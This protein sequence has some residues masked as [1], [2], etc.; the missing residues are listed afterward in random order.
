MARVLL[1]FAHPALEGSRV[2]RRLLRAVPDGVTVHDLYD[3]Y[4]DFGSTVGRLLS[5]NGVAPVVLD[6]DAD[7]VDFLRRIGL[8]VYYGDA[9][10]V[11]LLAMAGAA[12]ARL[13]VV[14]L[15]TPEQT[16]A[17]VETARAHFPH[18]RVYARAFEWD[19]AHDLIAA[20]ADVYR[21]SL[22][23]SLRV[24]RDVLHALGHRAYQA[25]RSAQASRAHDEETLRALTAVRGTGDQP[26]VTLARRRIAD[27]EAR[28]R[29]DRDA[30]RL[31][32]DGG[33]DAEPIREDVAGVRPARPETDATPGA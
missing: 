25:Q 4:P 19:D 9:S 33:W 17:L 1:L 12:D 13:L 28:F 32:R 21:E 16:L 24:G 23:T 10:R 2:H 5:A 29:A 20:G 30:G 6:V 27:L 31:D 14:A 3:V 7:R 15:G 26:Y 11:D 22:D 18:L 8:T